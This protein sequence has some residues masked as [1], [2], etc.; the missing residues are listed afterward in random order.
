MA[1]LSSVSGLLTSLRHVF[2]SFVL[3]SFL[4]AGEGGALL[5]FHMCTD[6]CP[7]L[8]SFGLVFVAGV[9][10]LGETLDLVILQQ[11]LEVLVNRCLLC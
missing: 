6:G 2:E 4:S 3:F 5:E 7:S 8:L 10:G 1:C 9:Y 11:L